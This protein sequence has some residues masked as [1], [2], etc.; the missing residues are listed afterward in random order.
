MS[1][2]EV[3]LMFNISAWFPA[4]NIRHTGYA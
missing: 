1:H 2:A 3:L 4:S